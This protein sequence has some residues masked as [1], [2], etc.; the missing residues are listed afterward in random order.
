MV[1][2]LLSE[3]DPIYQFLISKSLGADENC[4]MG[5]KKKGLRR[6]ASGRPL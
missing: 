3:T 6:L 4:K 1:I 2:S 5:L